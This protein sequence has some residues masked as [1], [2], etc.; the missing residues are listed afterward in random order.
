MPLRK[1]I[2]IAFLQTQFRIEI[3]LVSLCVMKILV[4]INVKLCTMD[5]FVYLFHTLLV[6]EVEKI[7]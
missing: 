6:S 5:I 2:I 7:R 3:P 4:C 1:T